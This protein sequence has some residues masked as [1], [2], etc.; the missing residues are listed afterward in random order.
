MKFERTIQYKVEFLPN[1]R[2]KKTRCM[3]KERQVELEIQDL[4]ETEFPIAFIVHEHASIF[5]N[6]RTYKDFNGEGSYELYSEEIRCYDGDLYKPVRISMGAAMSTLHEENVNNVIA[7]DVV[8]YCGYRDE[9]FYSDE[10]IIQSTNESEILSSMKNTCKKYK[11]YDGKFWKRCNEPFYR[12]YDGILFIEWCSP[13]DHRLNGKFFFSALERD[14][15]LKHVGNEF[16]R[17][18]NIEVKMPEMVKL[19]R[20]RY[21]NVTVCCQ[22]YYNSRIELPKDFNGTYDDALA[23][24]NAHLKEV[25]LG[26]LEYISDSDILDEEN[27]SFD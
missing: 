16:L 7:F 21:F 2:Y 3:I 8:S 26:G 1:K 11:Y 19:Y 24:A 4:E 18:I 23:Y 14:S 10:S 12:L 5:P 27:C 20:P 17:E 6:A 15:V 9:Q 13:S 22:A 25:P